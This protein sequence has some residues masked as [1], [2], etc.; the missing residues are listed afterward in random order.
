MRMNT[1]DQERY[2][3]LAWY[4]QRRL[5]SL[6]SLK[7]KVY[8]IWQKYVVRV[9]PGASLLEDYGTLTWGWSP[10]VKVNLDWTCSDDGPMTPRILHEFGK[11]PPSPEA[12][13]IVIAE[14]LASLP[15]TPNE[16]VLEVTL[17]HEM[18]HWNRL[19]VGRDDV[20]DENGP[21][22]PYAFEREAYGG[23]IRR[24]WN[25]CVPYELDPSG[26]LPYPIIP[27]RPYEE[28]R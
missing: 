23:V 18:I 21:N 26:M 17:L 1:E 16:V 4:L 8:E 14:D 15:N 27:A 5:P 9:P 24:T 20:Y 3:W 7:P 13:L 2:P 11:T 10:R 22:G 19:M 12:D 25:Y 6:P 28:P